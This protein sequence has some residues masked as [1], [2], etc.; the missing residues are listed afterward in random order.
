[1]MRMLVKLHS[2]MVILS[3]VFFFP[4]R[5][6]ISPASVIVWYCGIDSGHTRLAIC[7]AC[8]VFLGLHAIM[9]VIF[10]L[11]QS[12]LWLIY[13]LLVDVVAFA[14]SLISHSNQY[15]YFHF[16]IFIY[17]S[18]RQCISHIQRKYKLS[19]NLHSFNI[20]YYLPSFIKLSFKPIY[21][22]TRLYFHF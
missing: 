9:S 14:N 12:L 4:T 8:P 18:N 6:S 3:R 16:Y 5:N 10:H 19:F 1:M 7:K 17:Y 20:T 15:T 22:F 2:S 11:F 13:E 21:F